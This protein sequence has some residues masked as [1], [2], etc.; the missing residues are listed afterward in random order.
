MGECA[1][2]FEQLTAQRRGAQSHLFQSLPEP[3]PIAAYLKEAA[4]ERAREAA[5]EKAKEAQAGPALPRRATGKQPGKL[6]P[7]RSI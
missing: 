3:T 1:R 6:K 5:E 7:Q 4:E 2:H